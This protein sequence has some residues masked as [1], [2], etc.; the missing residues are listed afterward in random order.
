MA[1]LAALGGFKRFHWQQLITIPIVRTTFI[2]I[3]PNLHLPQARLRHNC[4]SNN[5]CPI[6]RPLDNVTS[7]ASFEDSRS[8]P[9]DNYIKCNFWVAPEFCPIIIE[10]PTHAAPGLRITGPH[11][12]AVA[13][14]GCTRVLFTR[15]RRR[16]HSS[17]VSP[18]PPPSLM[19]ARRSTRGRTQ[20]LP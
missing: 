6:S 14:A 16:H 3:F 1:A 5:F 15:R 12:L 19:P 8:P 13:V 10:L 7:S 20:S 17:P 11:P 9:T 4:L 2:G 18:S